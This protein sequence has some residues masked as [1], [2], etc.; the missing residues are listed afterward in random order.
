[1]RKILNQIQA[2]QYIKGNTNQNG[3]KKKQTT[4]I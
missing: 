4:A 3:Q 2:N 1:M